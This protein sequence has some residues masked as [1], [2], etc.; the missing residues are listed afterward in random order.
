MVSEEGIQNLIEVL[1]K[2]YKDEDTQNIDEMIKNLAKE[3]K[4][5]SI[6]AF[7]ILSF[8]RDKNDFERCAAYL[9]NN[10]AD[11]HARFSMAAHFN[12][13]GSVL[14]SKPPSTLINSRHFHFNA[15]R[16]L[17]LLL[18]PQ[19][20]IPPE[21]GELPGTRRGNLPLRDGQ[22]GAQKNGGRRNVRPLAA[23]Q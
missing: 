5:W 2:C 11:R 22:G 16:L 20:A 7:E 23:G 13:N 8:L 18:E 19:R 4:L 15:R 3:Y 17:L 6:Q 21:P 12:I 14:Q 10:V 9:F 1:L